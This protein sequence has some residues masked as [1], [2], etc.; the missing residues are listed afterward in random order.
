MRASWPTGVP[1]NVGH[2]TEAFRHAGQTL[3]NWS[4]AGARLQEFVER[5]L[6][7][8]IAAVVAILA[9]IQVASF[10]IAPRNW[11]WM[12]ISGTATLLFGLAVARTFRPTFERTVDRLRHSGTI[13][14]IEPQLLGE[15][16]A[17]R[18]EHWSHRTGLVISAVLGLAFLAAYGL[19]PLSNEA[20][21]IVFTVVSVVAA[22]VIGRYVGQAMLFGRLHHA[23]DESGAKLVLQPGHLDGAAGWR[24]LGQLYFRQA[25]LLALPAAHLG[26]WWLLIPMVDDYHEWRQPYAW[27]L[28][29]VVLWELAAFIGP[30]FA[31][32]TEMSRQKQELLREA[33]RAGQEFASLKA[34]L[35]TA[36]D[37]AV[38]TQ[39]N[40]RLAVLTE[41]YRTLEHVPTW[42]VDRATRRKFTVNHALLAVPLVVSWIEQGAISW[43]GIGS[44]LGS[45][46]E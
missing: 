36:E 29:V 42:P 22:Y 3:D 32:H 35:A 33:D 1:F 10:G 28:A 23:C 39:L 43:S 13:R 4:P 41:R 46:L 2:P 31:F 6:A 21:V 40:E 27:L 37:T 38:R 34:Q 12:A 14:E 11:D 9:I 44:S 18:L 15:W 19:T 16:F 25:L 8:I 45:W 7:G 30:M 5:A 20:G 24:P 26:A 17:E